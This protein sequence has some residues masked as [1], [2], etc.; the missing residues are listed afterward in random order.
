[1][2]DYYCDEETGNFYE[3]IFLGTTDC[4]KPWWNFWTGDDETGGTEL[5]FT[6][7]KCMGGYILNKCMTGACPTV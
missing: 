5:E 1:M 6:T 4:S 2:K 3:K 7:D